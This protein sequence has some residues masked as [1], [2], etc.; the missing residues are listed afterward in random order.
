MSLTPHK[1]AVLIMLAQMYKE[2]DPLTKQCGS[3]G[4]LARIQCA[5]L[6]PWM[7]AL[8]AEGDGGTKYHDLVEPI[9]NVLATMIISVCTTIVGHEGEVDDELFDKFFQALRNN[10][11]QL[12]DGGHST[13]IAAFVSTGNPGRA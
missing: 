13:V 11:D 2:L 10:V 12:R 7:L 8:A 1:D 6:E 9:G 5:V 4:A 3:L